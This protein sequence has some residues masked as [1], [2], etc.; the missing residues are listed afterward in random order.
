MKIYPAIDLMDGKAVRLYKGQKEQKKIYG[1]PVEIALKYSE[2]FEYLHIID[3]DGAFE[4]SPR[5]LNVISEIVK[6]TGMK[7]QY[8]G[9]LRSLE[10]IRKAYAAGISSAIIGTKVFDTGFVDRLIREFDSITVSLDFR[11]GKIA[12]EG[13]LQESG[14]DLIQT[15]S[16]LRSKF[17]RFIFTDIE[18]DGTNSGISDLKNFWNGKEV[19]YAGGISS[20]Q[21]IQKA[22]DMGFNGVIVGKA[23]FEGILTPDQLRE[24]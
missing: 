10:D 4:A 2:S 5:H 12:T 22:E 23:L 17:S 3:L 18:K 13:W 14:K 7:I 15:F 6:R 21:D 16:D 11:K 8:G 1:D 20:I 24:G 9:G 19:L